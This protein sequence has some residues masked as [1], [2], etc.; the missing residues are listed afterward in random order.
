MRGFTGAALVTLLLAIT[1]TAWCQQ[2]DFGQRVADHVQATAGNLVGVIGVGAQ[3]VGEAEGVFVNG[4][5]NFPMASTY[6]VAIAMALLH[7]VDRGEVRLDQMVAIAPEAVV[8]SKPIASNFIHPGVA[9]SVANLLEVMI[10]HSDNTATDALLDLTGGA[11]EVTHWLRSIGIENMRVD[12]RT[13]DILRDFYAVEPG[14]AQLPEV[15]HM[16]LTDPERV[17]AAD[18][19]FEADPRDQATPR[20]MLKLLTALAEKRVLSASSSQLLLEVMGRTITAPQRIRGLLPPGVA[21]AHKSGT[22]GGV[23][24]DVGYV[25]LP[26]G[27]QLAIVVFTRSSSSPP[28]RRDRAV[29]EAART[30][31]DYFAVHNGN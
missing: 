28:D 18:P 8:I 30:L 9:L 24:N 5:T 16:S 14:L 27:R 26:D 23:A 13:A 4:D 21:T 25:T 29:A 12:R 31:Y 10:V 22:I 6:K 19:A 3:V 17:N 20:A 11:K 2:Q 7:K 15:L 1:G